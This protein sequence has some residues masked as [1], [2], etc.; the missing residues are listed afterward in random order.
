MSKNRSKAKSQNADPLE[1]VRRHLAKGLFRD[2]L[3][4]ARVASRQIPGPQS[5]LLLEQVMLAR[6]QELIRNDLI[7]QA[8]DLLEP[9]AK[10]STDPEIRRALPELLLR[11]G[12]LGRFPQYQGGATDEVRSKLRV[13]QFDR[14][15]QDPE[16]ASAP[17]DKEL[18]SLIR[19]S[20]RSLEQSQDDAALELLRSVP[21]QS[22]G[23]EW[24]VFIRGLAGWYRHDA[25]AVESNWSRLEAERLPARLATKL[26]VLTATS[27]DQCGDSKLSR[28]LER[29]VPGMGGLT[30]LTQ[31]QSAIAR[32]D[33]PA[34]FRSY[35]ECRNALRTSDPASLARI[36]NAM[37]SR[38][39]RAGNLDLV[40]QFRRHA[41][42][43]PFDPRGNRTF[44]LCAEL[45]EWQ[46]DD[47]EEYWKKYLNDLDR[48]EHFSPADRTL[49][50]SLVWGR[51]AR[52]VSGKIDRPTA[53]DGGPNHGGD[54]ASTVARVRSYFE[55][56][57][58]ANPKNEKVWESLLTF[59]Q[60]QENEPG[61]VVAARQ[62]LEHF[63]NNLDT[64]QIV[65]GSEHYVGD[66]RQVLDLARRAY[67]L[68]PLDDGQ[69]YQLMVTHRV[70][71]L[72]D[73]LDGNFDAAR[74]QQQGH[75]LQR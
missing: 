44:A 32:K 33:W 60:S 7:H 58:Q 56:S 52:W 15:V 28:F 11:A 24:R 50:K 68:R 66:A 2:A 20:L 10:S 4:L 26:K 63:P 13:E 42:P 18:V 46:E 23:S 14:A 49:A 22:P 65:I 47:P 36:T 3:K 55:S 40:R 8:I 5:K 27:S 48:I 59:E 45:S 25:E 54:S 19:Q 74:Q 31:L 17:E 70:S 64:L 43:L 29:A 73:M 53:D 71:A 75:R 30:P 21:R 41:E 61:K 16:R 72:R 57:L 34:A 37:A 12:I 51:M 35:E 1:N 6:S 62:M 69:R 9:L 39:I 38:L 67:R